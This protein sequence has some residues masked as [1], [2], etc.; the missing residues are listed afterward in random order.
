MKAKAKV[1]NTTARGRCVIP[2]ENLKQYAK[3]VKRLNKDGIEF[4]EELVEDCT[5]NAIIDD[6]RKP[7]MIY[8]PVT[9][10]C[11]VISYGIH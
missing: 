10:A 2:C 11:I 4:T 9:A 7:K 1:V 8:K 5:Y 3:V 6:P